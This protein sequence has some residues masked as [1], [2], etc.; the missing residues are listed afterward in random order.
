MK[1][2]KNKKDLFAALLI[3]V[4]AFFLTADPFMRVGQP[5]TFDGLTH[6]TTMAQ[7][8]TALSQGEFPVVWAD[9]FANYG[10]PIPLISQQTTNHVAAMINFFSHDIL[11]A[12]NIIVF[13]GAL[14][15]TL[16][17]YIFLRFYFKPEVAFLGAYLFNF[18]SYRI[19]NIYIRGA[20]P[21]YF[22]AVFIPLVLIGLHTLSKQ[23][24]VLGA[25]ITIFANALLIFT[26]PFMFLVSLFLTVPYG[27]FLCTQLKEKKRF[28]T[29]AAISFVL[30]V[31][32]STIYTIP[33]VTEIRYFYYGQ[34]ANHILPNQAL[35]FSNYFDPNWYYYYKNDVFVRG[36][37]LSLGLL[38]TLC[39]IAGTLAL[40]VL[41][42]Q[43]RLK[44]NLLLVF[45]ITTSLILIFFTTQYAYPVYEHINLLGNIQ[46]PWRMLSG[47]VFI[48]PIILCFLV[49]KSKYTSVIVIICIVLISVLRFPQI[50]GKNYTFYPQ[51]IYFFT[52]DNLHASVLNTVWTRKTSEY[53]IKKEKPDIISG[54]GTIISKEVHNAWRKYTVDAKTPL[55]MI[56]YT[57]YF[58]GWRAYVDGQKIPIE[59][60]NPDY[61][62]VIT[63][64]VP[65][66]KHEVK[67]EFGPTKERLIGVASFIFFVIATIFFLIILKK[68][69]KK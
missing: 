68:K 22:A 53:P 38:E 2:L 67:L 20:I 64:P 61:R 46:Y 43:K 15:S 14:F 37:F 51:K 41:A 35:S 28:L 40:I 24:Y 18:S 56:D 59:Y 60:Q 4:I 19:I 7:Y 49:S 58:P 32:L 8:Y 11:A 21:E 13:L 10:M 36:N 25:A 33:L 55:I 52:P 17:F 57:F 66:G 34:H 30:G 9:G 39:L 29:I 47:L 50:Y 3:F 23:K 5:A 45:A 27:I 31:G 6:I 12:Y 48:P 63:Y 42:I 26:H 65:Q 54:E 62:G 69:L 44:K 1:L 16:L